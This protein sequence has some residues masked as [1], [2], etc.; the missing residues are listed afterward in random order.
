M[1]LGKPIVTFDLKETRVTAQ[2][3]AIYVTPNNQIEFAKAIIKLMDNPDLRAKKG[4]YGLKR[5]LDK[6]AWHHVSEN[7]LLAYKHLFL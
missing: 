3:E 7:L 5:I 1:A 6:L 2:D 4:E